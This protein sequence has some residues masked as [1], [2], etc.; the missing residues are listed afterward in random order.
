LSSASDKFFQ[1]FGKPSQNST[2]IGSRFCAIEQRPIAA[3][4]P[5]QLSPGRLSESFLLVQYIKSRRMAR[6]SSSF[7]DPS[8][9]IVIRPCAPTLELRIFD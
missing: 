1:V 3:R 4:F 8:S 6:N 7:I 5:T 2:S 9:R